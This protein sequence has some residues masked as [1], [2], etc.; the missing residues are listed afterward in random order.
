MRTESS[1]HQGDTIEDEDVAGSARASR[2]AG[3]L[4]FVEQGHP[5]EGPGT[6]LA[7]V[8]LHIRVRLEVGTQVGAVG[9]GAAAVGAGKGLLTW[10]ETPE[11]L[12]SPG[13]GPEYSQASTGWG[14]PGASHCAALDTTRLLSLQTSSQVA[15]TET[16]FFPPIGDR[17]TEA[18]KVS[19]RF[20][21]THQASIAPGCS[22]CLRQSSY[23]QPWI[24][25][26]WD[27]A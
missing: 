12:A 3:L 10:G 19:G 8:S 4:V 22:H 20:Q 17:E 18:Q 7:L 23:H 27:K 16:E 26:V 25:F 9:K 14:S 5:G 2:A 13:Q 6:G 1:G 21:V 11:G 15:L 24:Y